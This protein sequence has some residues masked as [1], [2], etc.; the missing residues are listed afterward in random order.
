MQW[1]INTGFTWPDFKLRSCKFCCVFYKSSQ[2]VCH[3]RI[4][5]VRFDPWRSLLPGRLY[6]VPC[7][8]FSKSG[9]TC[10]FFIPIIRL[11]SRKNFISPRFS[12]VDYRKLAVSLS[13]TK[14]FNVLKLI[15]LA[16]CFFCL[17]LHSVV[18]SFYQQES[19]N[20]PTICYLQSSVWQTVKDSSYSRRGMSV[21]SV[22]H[23]P[24]PFCTCAS[25]P[26]FWTVR[27]SR[28]T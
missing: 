15:V 20:N 2:Q 21:T 6:S 13:F 14:G 19:I 24:N 28:S 26:P 17:K 12:L 4:P 5:G 27:Y 25:S 7:G 10:R 22:Y 18:S 3:L 1:W 23:L 16:G 8:Q 11:K 9:V